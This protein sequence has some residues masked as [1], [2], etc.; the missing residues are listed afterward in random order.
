MSSFLSIYIILF[1]VDL[2][3]HVLALALS[4]YATS[5]VLKTGWAWLHRVQ[6]F[7]GVAMFGEGSSNSLFSRCLLSFSFVLYWASCLVDYWNMFVSFFFATMSLKWE[8]GDDLLLCLRLGF[9]VSMGP[10]IVYWGVCVFIVVIVSRT[11]G[12]C[13]TLKI[14]PLLVSSKMIGDDGAKETTGQRLESSMGD[15]QIDKEKQIG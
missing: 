12:R 1:P 10:G 14:G 8:S 9:N 11:R 13:S 2:F 5:L 3:V 4:L 7:S 15:C 6:D